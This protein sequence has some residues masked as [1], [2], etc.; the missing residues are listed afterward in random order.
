MDRVLVVVNEDVITQSEFDYRLNR[1]KDEIARNPNA[2]GLPPNFIQ[3]LLDSL[4][5]DHIQL[6]E[7]E[8]RGIVISDEE[9]DA[10]LERLAGQENLTV[11]QFLTLSLIHI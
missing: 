4:V 8:R 6:Q 1:I 9:V 2:P 7:A 10:A 5:L 3:Q 11:Q